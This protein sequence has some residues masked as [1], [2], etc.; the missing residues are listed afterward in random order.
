ML[1]CLNVITSYKSM[2]VFALNLHHYDTNIKETLLKIFLNLHC[3]FTC[4]PLSGSPYCSDSIPVMG[5]M[6]TLV[7]GQG[8]HMNVTIPT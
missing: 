3:S 2:D 5:S 1:E 7:Y 8:L 4:G 6:S